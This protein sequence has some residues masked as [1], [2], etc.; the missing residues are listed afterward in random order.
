MPKERPYRVC[1]LRVPFL[2]YRNGYSFLT[3]PVRF[4]QIFGRNP[5]SIMKMYSE[6]ICTL[7]ALQKP[8]RQRL[9]TICAYFFEQGFSFSRKSVILKIGLIGDRGII[10][11]SPTYLWVAHP[12]PSHS[13]DYQGG[14]TIPAIRGKYFRLFA[15][16]RI[17]DFD[18]SGE[19][20]DFQRLNLFPKLKNFYKKFEKSPY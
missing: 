1:Q 15:N 2:T 19:S 13:Y 10:K 7:L 6:I 16:M 12:C 9:K 17:S 11:T 4:H 3:H 8:L 14:L 20:F 5:R 18:R